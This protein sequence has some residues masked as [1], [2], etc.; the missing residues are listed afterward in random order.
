[1][2]DKPHARTWKVVLSAL[3]VL[4][5]F[6]LLTLVVTG[7]RFLSE[8]ASATGFALRSVGL[9]AVLV[10]LHRLRV[11]RDPY[12]V[13]LLVFF[14]PT[15]YQFHFAGGR[16]NGDGPFYYAYLRSM[17]KDGDLHFANE[18]QHYQLEERPDLNVPTST[19]HRRNIFSIGPAVVWSPF[20]A[21]GEIF[22]RLQ[23]LFTG[24]ANLSGFGPTH[25]NAVALG[26]C[27]LGFVAVWLVYSL[28]GKYFEPAAAF[29][30]AILMW[31]AT[32]LHWYM[33]QQ[34]TM[35]H[36]AS[37]FGATLS[38]WYWEK[39]HLSRGGRGAFLLG[40]LFGLAICIRWQNAVFL[41]LPGIDLLARWR[42]Q[43]ARALWLAAPLGLGVLLGALPQMLAWKAIYGEYLLRHPPQG[44]DF[45]RLDSPFFPDA[46]FSSRHGLLSWTPVLWL[47]YLGLVPALRKNARLVG[48][49]MLCLAVMTYINICSGDWWAGGSFSNRRF[50]SSLPLFAFGLA[51]S[52]EILKNW[53]S[54]HPGV[55]AGT[56]LAAFV[57]WNFLLM[58]QFRRFL[59]PRDDTVSFTRLTANNFQILY[60][61]VG[62][63]LAWPA[64]WIFAA[65]YD[66]PF[67]TY[68]LAVGRY[69][70]Y[71]QN[72]LG[73]VIELGENDGGLLG[74]GWRA[75]ERREG[76]WLRRS[77]GS[78]AR[79]LAPLDTPEPFRLVF[80]ASSR[81]GP[82]DV[83]V[84]VNGSEVGRFPVVPG[85]EEYRLLVPAFRWRRKINTLDLFLEGEGELLLDRVV[86]E[87]Q[88][89]SG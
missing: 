31:L 68:D 62:A 55:T 36:A 45:L 82:I 59:V 78:F 81:P 29:A 21:L 53:I 2:K 47:G 61:T 49:L 26:S 75:P 48:L 25:R 11:I 71:R 84:E 6:D 77:R 12:R 72:N 30:G 46:F 24:E 14:L 52:F 32:D 28:L 70:F 83:R 65:R 73:G 22:A 27:L 50:D 13:A 9:G 57:L 74:R 85:F 3:A 4:M 44:A 69:L 18:Y 39:S 23:L 64:N 20:F 66:V 51:A 38:L 19:G 33:V 41:L 37:T 67:E 1:M 76:V 17:W 88:E 42:E 10:V 86:F 80:R 34:P 58:E 16:V 87:P 89:S 40:L 63:P 43:G 8:E 35:S 15:L 60:Q 54:K 5:A 79:L 7:D 56:G